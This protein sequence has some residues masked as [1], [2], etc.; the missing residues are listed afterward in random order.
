LIN[1]FSKVYFL[2]IENMISLYDLTS[3]GL[4]VATQ[5]LFDTKKFRLEFCDNTLLRIKEPS[6]H[7]KILEMKREMNSRI[8]NEKYFNGFK[9]ILL[10]N[11][12]K[13]LFMVNTE[14]SSIDSTAVDKIVRSG[15]E[16][17]KKIIEAK[18]F[19]EIRELEGEFKSSITLPVYELFK[20]YLGKMGLE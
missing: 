18:S 16:L 9:A 1:N 6:L 8:E 2:I 7:L 20:R 17:M 4:C 11:I 13:I 15:K 3:I 14:Y 10:N 12:D 5:Q 19:E